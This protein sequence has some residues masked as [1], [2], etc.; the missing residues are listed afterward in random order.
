MRT[1]EP[2]SL[3]TS[4]FSDVQQVLAHTLAAHP[5]ASQQEVD[6]SVAALITVERDLTYMPQTLA[7]VFDQRVL[8]AVVVIADCSGNTKEPLYSS[9]ELDPLPGR[10]GALRKVSIEI[11]RAHGAS[12][13]GDAVRRALG[14]AR[15][16]ASVRALW[17]LHDDSKPLGTSCLETLVETWRD[18]PTASVLG[19]KQMDWE[20]C[21]LH[22]VGYYAYQGRLNSL[23]VD[24]E[25]DQEQYDARQDVFA[26]SVTGAL[27]PLQTLSSLSGLGH[28]SGTFGQ[29][30]DFCRRVCLS[31]GRVVVV[32]GAA[33]G[34]Y[35]ARYE[36]FRSK[37][38]DEGQARDPRD[39]SM[40]VIDAREGYCYAGHRLATWPM[41]WVLRLF[42]ALWLAV[43][44][45]VSKHPYAAVC[46]LCSPWRVLARLPRLISARRHLAQVTTTGMGQLESLELSRLQVKQ[47]RMRQRAYEDQLNHPLLNNLAR[48]HLRH[49]RTI[50]VYWALGM[51]ALVCAFAAVS[52]WNLLKDLFAGGSLHSNY[53]LPSAA[54]L[55][56][57]AQA[58]TVP[59]TWGVGLGA[60]SAPT[61]FLLLLLPV[62]V[63]TGGHI[64]LAMALLLL[65]SLPLSALSFWA[66]AG[67]F[68]RS[69][70]IRVLSGLLWTA[71]AFAL[72]MYS[73]GDVPNLLVMAFMPAAFA[74]TFR[75]VG[76]Y[77]TEQPSQPHP[78]ARNA[79]CAALCFT[80]IVL[81]E[82][83]LLLAL[84][85]VFIFFIALVVS[86]RTMLMLIP[87]PAAL[88]MAPTLVNTV[89]HW[90]E[91]TWRQLFGDVMLTSSQRFGQPRASSLSQLVASLLGLHIEGSPQQWLEINAWP[92]IAALLALLTIGVI[93]LISLCLPSISRVSRLMWFL[94]IVGSALALVSTGLAV[95]VD[96]GGPVAGS[97]LPG[98]L[99]ALLGLLACVSMMA[100]G[101]VR[102]FA[103]LNVRRQS[104]YHAYA[105]LDNRTTAAQVAAEAGQA[106]AQDPAL[107]SSQGNFARLR[108][109]W[110]WKRCARGFLAVVLLAV[111]AASS[112]SGFM[113]AQ[114]M[115]VRAGNGG[116]PMVAVD[117]IQHSDRHRILALG[118][119]REGQVGFQAMRTGRGDL[120]D[121][122]AS[123]QALRL[124]G[125]AN[126]TDR[127]LASAAAA[128]MASPDADAI[129]AISRL[130]FAG[131]FVPAG[132]EQSSGGQS[133]NTVDALTTNI[134]ASD[135]VQQVVASPSGTYFRITL[136]DADQ[137][138]VDTAGQQAAANLWWRPVWL[139]SL[140][141]VLVAYALVALPRWSWV[142]GS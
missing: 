76:M 52:S 133:S 142:E 58:A 42:L 50:R 62:A 26:V 63:L 68:T 10:A 137:Q 71:L 8:P 104:G 79:A 45:L 40:Q 94:A 53:L 12:S 105:A 6:A 14:Y 74:F 113:L 116:L 88:A 95:G 2:M 27:V 111:L 24:G 139:W 124:S 85:V 37:S 56:Q 16:P 128:L 84:V 100:G 30:A 20:G 1:L 49:Q 67:I 82:P 108:H 126:Q 78:S 129:A 89:G 97:P 109:N 118:S 59:W 91:G 43:T 138:G 83:Q 38:D 29:S 19:A 4:T 73:D 22:N 28:W 106:L 57:L 87:L 18:T 5:H 107:V 130:G 64:D 60:P 141:V 39:S 134:T 44:R 110:S 17:L 41:L 48:A 102:P 93:A 125:Q 81:A 51:V 122:S 11:V 15:L 120:V 131:I 80:V 140:S 103:T 7:A 46:E 21:G 119:T 99:L 96:W 86:H 101:A 33:I 55:S 98:L 121:V 132:Q 69:N 136:V 23:V 35:R 92:Q 32:P 25:P 3:P 70:P 54:S 115:N 123:A 66:L 117:Y 31:G 61:P 13:F 72:P 135:G 9:F 77:Y 75:A 114:H 47:W 65:V 90:S 112:A 127:D 34:H 36:G